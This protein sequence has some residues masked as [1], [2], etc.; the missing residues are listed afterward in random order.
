MIEPARTFELTTPREVALSLAA[1]CKA[2]RLARDWKRTTLA[3]RAGVSP[4]SLKRFETTGQVS[5][6]SFL[7]LCG[8]LGRLDEVG[9]LLQPPPARSIAELERRAA[10]PRSR[11]GRR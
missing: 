5:L 11:R 7:K 1:R 6:E 2:L 10:R 4:A 8:A 9:A 3:A